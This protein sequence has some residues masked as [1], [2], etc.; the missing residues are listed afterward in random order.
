MKA[1]VESMGGTT[2]EII[3][4]ST[5]EISSPAGENRLCSRMPH[6]SAVWSW[7]VRSRHWQI[8]LRPS[9][10]PMVILLLSASRASSTYASRNNQ[11]ICSVVFPHDQEARSVEPGGGPFD[12][13]IGL[14][15]ADV[16]AGSVAR[17]A[18]EEPE[19][20]LRTLGRVAIHCAQQGDEHAGCICADLQCSG[21]CFQI[22][23]KCRLMEIDADACDGG[24]AR[25]LHQN[26]GHFFAAEHHIV[27]PAQIALDI[28]GLRDGIGGSESE[29]QSEQGPRFQHQR[30][31]ETAVGRGV[32]GVSVA[33]LPGSL[34]ARN[35][36][37]ARR[38]PRCRVHG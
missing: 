8:S 38:A 13:A 7:T 2:L 6:S 29:R 4:P 36:D 34:L 25:E 12:Y 16:A 26:A 24:C 5:F 33:P 31:I 19:D 10:A 37:V 15:Y 21:Q 22:G 32:P 1:R 23:R 11:G 35:N 30:A 3:M 18:R 28:R 20:V 9:K 27:R 17:S 14:L